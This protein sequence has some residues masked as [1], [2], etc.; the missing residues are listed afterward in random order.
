MVAQICRMSQA[1]KLG[2]RDPFT[3][4][5]AVL[6]SGPPAIIALSQVDSRINLKTRISIQ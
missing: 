5:L 2:Y 3:K 6:A 4:E 1:K